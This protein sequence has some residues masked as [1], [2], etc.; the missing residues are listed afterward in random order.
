[1]SQWEGVVQIKIS[2]ILGD[3]HLLPREGVFVYW[4]EYGLVKLGKR[5]REDG[6]KEETSGQGS[7]FL[8]AEKANMV[9][10]TLETLHGM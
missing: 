4:E 6:K 5:E 3:Q 9:T 7:L 10:K 2:E 1:M 8:H